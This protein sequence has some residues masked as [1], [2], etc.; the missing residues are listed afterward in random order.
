VK[1]GRR[2]LLKFGIAL[3]AI[4]AV[5]VGAMAIL[6][7]DEDP[8]DD[9]DMQVTWAEIPE[10]DNA[11]TYINQA[12]QKLYWPDENRSEPLDGMLSGET[13][14]DAL[15]REVLER[16]SETLALFKNGMACPQFQ[17]PD[18][19][20]SDPEMKNWVR[21]ARVLSLR[22]AST[23]RSGK[24]QQAFD[25][26]CQLVRFGYRCENGRGTGLA[27]VLGADVKGLGGERIRQMLP[28]AKIS[29]KNLQHIQEEIGA[30][31][32]NEKAFTDT[33]RA[34][35]LFI[36]PKVME[37]GAPLAAERALTA[38]NLMRPTCLLWTRF[39]YKP[40]ESARLLLDVYRAEV[41]N[42][43]RPYSEISH[44]P[45]PIVLNEKGV[46]R[47][48]QIATAYAGG[49]AL[50][51]AYVALAMP[52]SGAIAEMAC[53]ERVPTRATIVLVA[54]KAYKAKTGRL[55][56]S[57][58]E[59]VPEHLGAVPVDD[60]DGKPLRYSPEKKV[61]YS[62]GKD[63]ADDGGSKDNDIVFEID[64]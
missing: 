31:E 14:D 48:W 24:H 30:C 53:K 29:P 22:A 7:I 25:Q 4:A 49:N 12:A 2:I 60:M 13:W 42:A 21:L 34:E 54:L 16:N 61:L 50:G 17:F 28:Q 10:A 64:F 41:R 35:Y 40:N 8:P 20:K 3:A 59:L 18:P 6:G 23:F 57:L 45:P 43:T 37:L 56:Q 5:G 32:S 63:L 19:R 9:S 52:G 44:L 62:V 33:I 51:R 55:P 39:M 47:W 15:A 38:A 36:S 1:R 26:A 58:T 46:L 27:T 11:F